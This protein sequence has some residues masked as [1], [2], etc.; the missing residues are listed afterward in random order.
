MDEDEKKKVKKWVK[1][2]EGKEKKRKESKKKKEATKFNEDIIQHYYHKQYRSGV[3]QAV[4]RSLSLS[5]LMSNHD[6]NRSFLSFLLIFQFLFILWVP[7]F[8]GGRPSYLF[9][10]TE[11]PQ[12]FSFDKSSPHT[13]PINNNKGT[14]LIIQS[15]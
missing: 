9:L 11:N 12:N 7:F 5:C 14:L 3:R 2:G 8:V 6:P 15:L 13:C 10:K 4:G 1:V